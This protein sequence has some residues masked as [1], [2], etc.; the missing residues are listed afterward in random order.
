LSS[1]REVSLRSG[2][3]VHQ[4]LAERGVEAELVDVGRD[5]A[6][7][8]LASGI[9]LAYIALHGRFGED[10]CI[11]GLLEILGIPYTGSRVLASAIGMHKLAT[12]RI[13]TASGIP[14]PDYE[15][16]GTGDSGVRLRLAGERLGFPLVLKPVAEGSSIAVHI[17]H[18]GASL[19]KAGAGIVGEYGSGFAEA[20]V[21]GIEV[22]TG[23]LGG[24]ADARA[25]PV[26]Q[27]VP[28]NEFY[29]YDAKYT[30]G[31]T[32]FI[33]PARLEEN[34]YR[35]VQRL[36]LET[37]RAIGCR[38]VSRVDAIVRETT[39]EVMVIEINTLPGMTETSDLPAQAAAAGIAFPD[40]VLEILGGALDE[41]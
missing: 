6:A 36:A 12:K 18:D 11:Q 41:Q 24:D 22:T 39:G 30:K 14:T 29:D 20:F 15:E 28:H 35:E 21:K 5:I 9:N 23:V 33:L 3:N 17:V 16:F 34:V 26:L 13:L 25:L 38:G 8:L 40:L 31:K 19:E 2:R 7:R 4:A 27:L 10:G 32:D 37:H 1:E